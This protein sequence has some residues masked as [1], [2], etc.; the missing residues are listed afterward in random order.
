MKKIAINI[1]QEQYRTL[2]DSMNMTEDVCRMDGTPVPDHMR[3]LLKTLLIA[4]LKAGWSKLP[5]C[6]TGD[7]ELMDAAADGNIQRQ[8]EDTFPD[9]LTRH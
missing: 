4:G 7:K 1:D 5:V 3:Q 9:P 8:F 2:V 6:F